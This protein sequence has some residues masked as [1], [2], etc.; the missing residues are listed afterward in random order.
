MKECRW[1]DAFGRV[2][3]SFSARVEETLNEM[4]RLE[5]AKTMKRSAPWRVAL[6][7]VLVLV[8]LTGTALA[9]GQ[10]GGLI[11]FF[12][13]NTAITPRE[14]AANDIAH[15]VASAQNDVCRLTVREAAY[16]GLAV[17]V[18]M[19]LEA[20]QPDEVL[21]MDFQTGG[22]GLLGDAGE[23]EAEYA[24]R[25]GKRLTDVGFC[26][27]DVEGLPGTGTGDEVREGET[28]VVYRELILSQPGAAA[29]TLT[30]TA[31]AGE[32]DDQLKVSFPVMRVSGTETAYRVTETAKAPLTI[33]RAARTDSAFATYFSITWT[34]EPRENAPLDAE[35]T[36]YI[37]SGG[38]YA[39][40][41]PQCGDMENAAAATGAEAQAQGKLACPVCASDLQALMNP[42]NPQAWHFEG[43]ALADAESVGSGDFLADGTLAYTQHWQFQPGAFPQG[44]VVVTPVDPAGE[45]HPEIRLI[46]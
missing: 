7:A 31:Y 37:T 28:L 35:T 36:Y 45:K 16:D 18:V 17:R 27:I 42:A 40:T 9:L 30:V 20:V 12:R 14:D 15:D 38:R 1:K 25:V 19:A 13:G 24:R 5:G 29:E 4:K 41:K 46:P 39:H 10:G 8:A 43:D 21:Y 23:T 11:D 44:E 3:D 34:V 33:Q 6:A 2:P 32:G 26:D 22:E